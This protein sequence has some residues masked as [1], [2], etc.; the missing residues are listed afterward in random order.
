MDLSKIIQMVIN[1]V[2]KKVINRGVDAGIDYASKR[3]KSDD[4]MT[5]EDLQ[6]AKSAKEMAKRA[7]QVI[8]VGR[9]LGR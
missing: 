6:Q 7:K 2:L 8:N 5:P 9:K 1:L 4:Q 3:G